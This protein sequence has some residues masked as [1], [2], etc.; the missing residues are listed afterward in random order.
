MMAAT[1]GVGPWIVTGA[2]VVA[3]TIYWTCRLYPLYRDLWR[4][5]KAR[6]AGEA[7]QETQ[8]SQS[9]KISRRY[10]RNVILLAL[11]GLVV[12]ALVVIGLLTENHGNFPLWDQWILFVAFWSMVLVEGVRFVRKRRSPVGQGAELH[13]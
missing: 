3:L 11:S 1:D 4:R 13:R 6:L 5:R 9:P 10:S 12:L 7:S 8:A 2:V